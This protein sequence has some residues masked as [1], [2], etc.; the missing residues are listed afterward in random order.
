MKKALVT[1]AAGFIGSHVV[2]Q[3][4]AKGIDVRAAVLPNE[5]THNIDHYQP[6][7]VRGDMLDKDFVKEIVKD[8]D[9]V[10]HLAA[11]YATWMPDWKPLWE[12]NMQGSRNVLWACMNAKNVKKVVYT[13]S[14]SAIGLLPGRAASNE[15]TPFNQYDALPYI[16]SKYLSQQEA[17]DFAE[18]GLNLTVVNPAFP[19]GPGDVAPTPTGGIIMKMIEGGARFSF[20]GGFNLVDVR[21]V[22]AGHILAAEKGRQGEKYILGNENVTGEE[23]SKICAEILG[24][25]DRVIPLPGMLV[26]GGAQLAQFIADNITHSKPYIIPKELKYASQFAFMDCNKARKELGYNPRDVRISLRDS[27]AWFQSAEFQ[28]TQTRPMPLKTSVNY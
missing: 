12:V 16:L 15:T 10:F 4:T 17:L 11:V 3:L 14:L 5:R 24:K 20:P 1:G 18:Q 25:S 23:F 8:V 9:T 2:D 7:I 26:E 21:D 27:I 19:F 13:S 28:N 22:A 6:E